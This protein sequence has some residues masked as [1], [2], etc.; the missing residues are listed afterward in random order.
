[1]PE[2][3]WNVEIGVKQGLKIGGVMGYLDLA[4]FWQEYQNTIE[5]MFG[6]WD[7]ANPNSLQDLNF[8]IQEIPEFLE[9][10]HL[11]RQ[12][13]FGK[14]CKG[15]FN[16]Y[17]YIVPTTL[18]PDFVYAVDDMNREYSYNSTS[19][20]SNSGI[21]KYRFLHN[22]KLDAEITYDSRI[23]IGMSA[24]YLVK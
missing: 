4:G 9:L 13:K 19:L 14:K 7:L 2:S 15:T 24:K 10:T 18:N 21:L 8:L 5:Y 1:M 16:G 23:S 20:D 3:S 22:V 12:I 17:N 11:C 6:I